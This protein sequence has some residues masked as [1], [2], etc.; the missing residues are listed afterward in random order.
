MSSVYA[1]NSD[2]ETV[3][4]GE[5]QVKSLERDHRIEFENR[6]TKRFV[7]TDPTIVEL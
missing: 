3:G 5:L 4:V 1:W 2:E 7:S 6:L